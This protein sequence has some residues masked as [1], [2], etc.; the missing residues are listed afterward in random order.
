MTTGVAFTR[1]GVQAR[2]PQAK[3]RPVGFVARVRACGRRAWTSP[4]ARW[5][6]AGVAVVVAVATKADAL[7]A[8]QDV[9]RFDP[10]TGPLIA[11]R[12][13]VELRA[14]VGDGPHL[15]DPWLVLA[16]SS[17]IYVLDPPAFGVHHFDRSGEW[18]K[19]M[20]GEGEGPGEFRRPVAMGWVSD[21]MWVAD[22]GLSR[23]SF[24]GRQGEYV[25]SVRFS[26]MMGSA[27]HMPGRA[28]SGG[29]ILSMEYV[30]AFRR[31][32]MSEGGGCFS[33]ERFAT[34]PKTNE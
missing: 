14:A 16:D 1:G 7:V 11:L 18:L 26:V 34:R 29:G 12:K 27:V 19:T 3:H 6:W 28:L 9:G 5:V 17:H 32:Q 30:S 21:T 33:P 24:F 23:L 25:R 10:P 13:E 31:R 20:G 2:K 15:T 4:N 22:R 8:N